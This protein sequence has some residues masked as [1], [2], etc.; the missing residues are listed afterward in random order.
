MIL[1]DFDKLRVYSDKRNPKL[2]YESII[3]LIILC[4]CF[5]HAFDAIGFG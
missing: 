1:I 2:S 4:F 5:C 3:Y